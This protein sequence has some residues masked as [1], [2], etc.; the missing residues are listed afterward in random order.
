MKTYSTVCST[1]LPCPLTH[2][3]SHVY[4]STVDE[5]SGRIDNLEKSVGDLMTQAGIEED[6][7][8]KAAESTQN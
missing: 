4:S 3:H 2:L 1:K 8:K 6:A 7:D 5:I